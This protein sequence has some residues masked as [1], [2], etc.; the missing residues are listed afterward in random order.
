VRACVRHPAPVN[1]TTE[2]NQDEAITRAL[3]SLLDVWPPC[4]PDWLQPLGRVDPV[5]DL[6]RFLIAAGYT[7][8]VPQSLRK[9]R[10]PEGEDPKW[11][12]TG[13]KPTPTCGT[14]RPP[15]ASSRLVVG[16]P[17]P[18]RQRA[19]LGGHRWRRRG[20]GRGP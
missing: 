12:S 7:E 10:T 15:A 19:G 3:R 14:S 11:R 17:R 1:E 2:T 18:P 6:H 16:L 4:W 5:G 20:P 13:P 8:P 9:Q